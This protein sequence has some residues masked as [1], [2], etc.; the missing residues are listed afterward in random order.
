MT[1]Y[2]VALAYNGFIERLELE[3]N[4]MLMALRQRNAKKAKPIKLRNI[5]IQQEGKSDASVKQSTLDKREETF[6]HLGII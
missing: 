5:D 2:E 4:V 3:G 6:K 1:P